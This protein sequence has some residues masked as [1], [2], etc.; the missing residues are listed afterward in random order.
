MKVESVFSP[1]FL[2]YGHNGKLN[3][4]EYHRDSEVNVFD[5]DAVFLLAARNEL[6]GRKLNTEKI[7][8]FR[9]PAGTAIEVYGSTLHY[10]PCGSDNHCIGLLAG[11]TNIEMNPQIMRI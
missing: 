7:R 2:K 8:A 11:I 3:C 4:M 10:A 1:A 6:E 9:V 5:G